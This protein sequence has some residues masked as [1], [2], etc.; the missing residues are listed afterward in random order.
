MSIRSSRSLVAMAI[1]VVGCGKA[2]DGGRELPPATGP[3]A[4][5]LPSVPALPAADSA[6]GAQPASVEV[7][8]RKATG[9]LLP[10]SEVSVVARARGA[11]VA[12]EVEVGA[13][14]KRGQLLFRID[15]R[16][17]TLRLAQA[18]TQVAAAEQQQRAVEAEYNRTKALFEQQAATPQQWE[19]VSAQL[20]GA[21]V[22]VAQARNGA[23]VAAK[24]VTDA[25]ARAPI[26]GL[27]VSRSVALGNFLN[28]GEAALVL[29]DQA[30]LELRFRLPERALAAVHV[31]DALTVTVPAL[32]LARPAKIA[33]VGPS[34][35]TRTGTFELTALLDNRDGALR[36]GQM[37]QVELGAAAPAPAPAEPTAP[38]AAPGGAR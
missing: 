7:A 29:Q 1:L 16:E 28:D 5:P 11:V 19:L 33:I 32:G 6:A 3:G 4:P 18:Q 37:A 10:R 20:D 15:A 36:P 17:A 22:A 21:K 35:D 23:A 26:D 25:T 30:T 38:P 9:T 27:V 14:V 8:E 2:S 31:G 24:A 34:V 13:K 12:L